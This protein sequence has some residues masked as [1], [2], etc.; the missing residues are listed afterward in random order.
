MSKGALICHLGTFTLS[1][2]R[3]LAKH[4][5]SF[6]VSW[7][8]VFS[9][10]RLPDMPLGDRVIAAKTPECPNP[11]DKDVSRFKREEASHLDKD[12]CLYLPR[13]GQSL[14]KPLPKAS[15]EY[16][17]C[18]SHHIIAFMH[19]WRQSRLSELPRNWLQRILHES[20][21]PPLPRWKGI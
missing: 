18:R 8:T 15:T 17:L 12:T 9:L 16:G 11:S 20:L 7:E 5:L 14:K 19:T 4:E 2:F 21:S 1:R 10:C 6:V 3:P 13:H